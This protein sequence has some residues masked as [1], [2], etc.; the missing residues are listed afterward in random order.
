VELELPDT[1]PADHRRLASFC[2]FNAARTPSQVINGYQ[3]AARSTRGVP[4]TGDPPVRYQDVCTPDAGGL[5]A[6]V[7]VT[8]SHPQLTAVQVFGRLKLLGPD[9]ARWTTTP[10]G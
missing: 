10:L 4:P 8:G 2:P 3:V 5:F 1:L 6:E 7:A 9:P